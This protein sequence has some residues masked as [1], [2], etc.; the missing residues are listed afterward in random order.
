MR[1]A[2]QP[3]VITLAA[4][5]S[6]RNAENLIVGWNDER[7]IWFANRIQKAPRG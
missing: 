4:K 5:A 7:D 6:E 3:D 2:E 1:T